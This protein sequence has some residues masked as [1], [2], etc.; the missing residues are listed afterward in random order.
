MNRSLEQVKIYYDSHIAGKLEGF[1]EGNERVERAW[2]T[3]DQRAPANPKQILEIGC[4]IG[5]ICWRMTR[6]WPGAEVVGL[7]VSPNSL[8]MARKLFGSS[9]LSFCEGPLVIW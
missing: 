9:R 7:D 2:L 1:V 4:G 8:E 5:D 6:R 3:I